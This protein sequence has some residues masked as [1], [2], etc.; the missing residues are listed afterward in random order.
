MLLLNRI[1][2][3]IITS[4]CLHNMCIQLGDVDEDVYAEEEEDDAGED[5]ENCDERGTAAGKRK[6]QIIS[7]LLM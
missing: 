2:D 4:C 6:R 3:V 7:Y 1:P 5:D